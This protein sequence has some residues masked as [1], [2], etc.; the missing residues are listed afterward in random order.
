LWPGPRRKDD[1]AVDRYLASPEP[2]AVARPLPSEPSGI[3][4]RLPPAVLVVEGADD[5]IAAEEQ[6]EDGLTPVALTASSSACAWIE[7]AVNV[8]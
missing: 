2:R 5:R 7:L 8:A 6:H 4:V 3:P 1:D